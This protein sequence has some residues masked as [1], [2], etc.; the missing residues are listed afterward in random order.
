MQKHIKLYD[1]S[2]TAMLREK[3][4]ADN[5]TV[6]QPQENINDFKSKQSTF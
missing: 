5:T 3:Q 4:T 2:E 6:S 1:S